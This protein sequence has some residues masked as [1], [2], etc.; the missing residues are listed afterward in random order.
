MPEPKKTKR[1]YKTQA[2]SS[3]DGVRLVQ[4]RPAPST[5]ED[6]GNLLGGEGQTP[7]QDGAPGPELV[8]KLIRFFKS[9]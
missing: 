3:L 1:T 7:A 8:R 5:R 9:I 6:N 4:Q 2:N